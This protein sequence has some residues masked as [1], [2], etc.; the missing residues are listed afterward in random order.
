MLDFNT[1][2]IREIALE[3]PVTVRVFED[4]NIDYCCGGRIPFTEACDTAGINPNELSEK[5]KFAVSGQTDAAASDAPE[6]KSPS[7][8]ID[9]IIAKH[10]VFT[11][12][13]ITRLDELIKKVCRK[14]G[15]Q[16]PELFKLRDLFNGMAEDMSLHMRKEEA[17]LFPFIKQMEL[18]DTGKF[19][20]FAPPFG[21]V[22]NPVRMMMKE[23]DTAAEQFREMRDVTR[24]YQLPNDACPSFTGLYFGLRYL[25]KDLHRHV[26]LENNVL[27]DQA[28]AL[29]GRVFGEMANEFAG[30]CQSGH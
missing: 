27:F 17:M 4:H 9:Y 29:E 7:D 28:V 3:M 11:R 14:H 26:H 10:H 19:P 12:N 6:H 18:A 1:K 16:H 30:C 24:D 13:E 2:T 23:H 21:T 5:L 15:E 25:E 20:A 22:Q 8:L